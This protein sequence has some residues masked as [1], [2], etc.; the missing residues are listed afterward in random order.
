MF[1]MIYNALLSVSPMCES[2]HGGISILLFYC[3]YILYYLHYYILY[4]ITYSLYIV[5]LY[6]RISRFITMVRKYTYKLTR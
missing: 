4:V 6:S 2:L 1:D 5:G 3:Y